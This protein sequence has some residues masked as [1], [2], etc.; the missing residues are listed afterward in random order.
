MIFA[1]IAVICLFSLGCLGCFSWDSEVSPEVFVKQ[2]VEE[3]RAKDLKHAE[4]WRLGEQINWAADHETG[5][6][7]FKFD[8]GTVAT[9]PMQTIGTYTLADGT[10]MWGWDHPSVKEPL[11]KNA[12]L[13]LKFGQDNELPRYTTPV[14]ACTE[15]EAWEFTATAAKLGNANGAFWGQQGNIIFF[16]TFGEVSFSQ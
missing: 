8:D 4:D 16:M 9:A 10:F 5:V 1:V 14:V 2:A 15:E 11:R 12:K 6:I 13:A 7:A 3:V